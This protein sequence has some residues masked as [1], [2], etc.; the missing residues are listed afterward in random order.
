MT[1]LM[2]LSFR[3]RGSS[4]PRGM[5]ICR[6]ETQEAFRNSKK[7]H[8]FVGRLLMEEALCFSLEK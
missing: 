3:A 8:V 7:Y 1:N 4:P 6:E 2:L 5:P